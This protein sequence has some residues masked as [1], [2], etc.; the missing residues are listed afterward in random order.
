MNFK[1]ILK[2]YIFIIAFSSCK[3]TQDIDKLKGIKALA[4][5][6][7]INFNTGKITGYDTSSIY[8]FNLE[9]LVLFKLHY[10]YDSLLKDSYK[11]EIRYHYFIYQKGKDYGYDYDRYKSKNGIKISLDSILK[12]EWVIN[13]KIFPMFGN[14]NEVAL[15]TSYKSK[16]DDTLKESY[17]IKSKLNTNQSA[18]IY[19]E[20]VKSL[21]NFEFSL[22]KELD[23]VKNMKLSKIRIINNPMKINDTFTIS[24]F[25][26]YYEFQ[27]Y[28][29]FNKEEIFK[30][31][32]MFRSE[33]T[34]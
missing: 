1:I 15:L 31:I 23:S 14:I 12:S 6:P 30:Y 4:V 25:E 22:S 21:M 7:N 17:F 13:T 34:N 18:N 20:Y 29:I 24:K 32:Q 9:D 8:I 5:F 28:L 33:K 10:S 19:L 27:K 16:N 11:T 26:T 2:I 3:T